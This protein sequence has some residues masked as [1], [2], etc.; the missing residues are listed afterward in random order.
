[1]S[2]ELGG[3]SL[4]VGPY[5]GE[6]GSNAPGNVGITLPSLYTYATLPNYTNY[7]IGT[8]AYTT[9]SG[10]VYVGNNGW[11]PFGAGGGA[12]SINALLNS[13][14]T[15]A[16]IVVDTGSV[17][18]D[19]VAGQSV[20]VG[21]FS[22]PGVIQRIFYTETNLYGMATTRIFV[23][24]DGES[25]PSVIFD[26]GT[27]AGTAL[28]R[29]GLVAADGASVFSTQYC[30]F[31]MGNPRGLNVSVARGTVTLKF[32]VPFATSAEVRVNCGATQCF[33]VAEA[34]L[35]VTSQ[36]RLKSFGIT[37]PGFAPAW[38]SSINYT[39][40]YV[41]TASGS[42]WISVN[43]SH[44]VAPGTTGDWAAYP[45]PVGPGKSLTTLG[46]NGIVLAQINQPGWLAAF[47]ASFDSSPNIL[48]VL[49]CT[50]MLYDIASGTPLPQTSNFY[51]SGFEDFFNSAFYFVAGS[52]NALGSSLGVNGIQRTTV[53]PGSSPWTY[54]NTAGGGVS[55]VVTGG[56]VSQ[57][58]VSRDNSTYDS[59]APTAGQFYL[60]PGDYLQ[61][62]YS[63]A[64]TVAIYPDRE[65]AV[66]ANRP[67]VMVTY[68]YPPAIVPN[69][70]Q[71]QAAAM[72]DFLSQGGIYCRNGM[73][74]R[75]EN[76]PDKGSNTGA[77]FQAVDFNYSGLY[78]T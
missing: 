5:T 41:V 43:P 36:R 60:A 21:T 17:V 44:N 8:Q 20:L 37:S 57:I 23:Y 51:Y 61:I 33:C 4:G 76:P 56:T 67:D 52:T 1:M 62:T 3:R 29:T 73:L 49:E 10:P 39:R 72:R 54:Q 58:G 77:S 65:S 14:S 70:T 27:L 32:P 66:G 28:Y 64:P 50:P 48:N 18:P 30:T 74:L 38:S 69:A 55:V 22:G 35:G 13:P 34:Q 26:L 7:P 40:G 59:W 2:A 47:G 71:Q 16:T 19:P 75:L 46:T 6:Q 25:V 68:L 31:A 12:S 45:F 78:Y 24:V 15:A 11:T 42:I 63:V 53:S 9:D